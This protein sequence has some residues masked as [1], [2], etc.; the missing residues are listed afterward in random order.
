MAPVTPLKHRLSDRALAL[1]LEYEIG[2]SRNY[3]ETHLKHPTWPEGESGVTIMIGY[4]CGYYS[5]K[6]IY[7]DLTSAGINEHDASRLAATAG[8]TGHAAKRVADSLHDITIQWDEAWWVFNERT[9]PK[10]IRETMQAFPGAADKLT[11]DAFGALVSLV[12]NRGAGMAGGRRAQMRN[13][14]DLIAGTMNGPA[15]QMAIARE[16]LKM[17]PLWEGTSI[18]NGMKRRRE[19]E[20]ELVDG[21]R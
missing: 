13:I 5:D 11:E 3:Y 7:D 14:R 1:I 8:I 17:I 19:A 18:Y 6:V 2:G 16:I 20:A 10:Y 21:G 4:D 12:F 9:L 15:L